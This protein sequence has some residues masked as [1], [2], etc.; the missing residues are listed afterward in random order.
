[1]LWTTILG[2]LLLAADDVGQQN[3]AA[4]AYI[5][6]LQA[7]S[8]GFVNVAT[9]K[10][11]EPRDVLANHAH[12]SAWPPALGGQPAD[13]QAVVRY[14]KACYDPKSGGFSDRPGAK[15]DAIS[16]AVGL[17]ILGEL[18][19]PVEPYREA[20]LKFMN[21]NTEGFEQIRMVASALEEL[22]RRV[23]Q[24]KQWL[25][26]I[27]QARN[28]DGSYG[29]GFGKA[30]TTALYVVAQ[31]R[32]GGKPESDEAALKVLR[33]G[34]RADGGFGGDK[35]G[36]GRPRSVLPRGA[37]VLATQRPARPAAETTG[38]HRKLPE[39]RWR[40]WCT[41][42]R[43]VVTPRN[44]LCCHRPSLVERRQMTV[45]CHEDIFPATP[46]VRTTCGRGVTPLDSTAM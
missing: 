19:L 4:I 14:L 21:E 42:R 27:D 36:R 8:G 34:Q 33:A 18:H 17:M 39:R 37:T 7:P 3:Q 46:A 20:G 24:A 9:P 22:G 1:M 43:T 29:Q 13:H 31:Q 16:T 40:L 6:T 26:V 35:E 25:K 10:G 2:T 32:L 28:S 41:A 5:Q 23:P 44:L 12:G 15:P 45:Q 30:R 11:T 38:I